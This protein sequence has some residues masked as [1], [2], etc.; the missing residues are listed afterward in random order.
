MRIGLTVATAPLG[1]LAGGW[2]AEHAGLR[3]TMLVA[4][5]REMALVL[6]VAWASPLLRVRT[7]REAQE[8]RQTKS[9]TEEPAG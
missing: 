4:G 5:L 1:G 3:A 6:A 8:P 7:L 9:V 2:I